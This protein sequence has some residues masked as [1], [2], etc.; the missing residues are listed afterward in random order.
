MS[1]AEQRA[2]FEEWHAEHGY[3][4][5]NY[6]GKPSHNDEWF[7]F[8]EFVDASWNAWCAALSA[9]S[10]VQEQKPFAWIR[11]RSD[12]GIEGP[13]L[14]SSRDMCDVRRKSGAWTP[15]FEYQPSSATQVAGNIMVSLADLNA[16]NAA[17]NHMGD[18]LNSIDAVEEDDENST[19]EGFEAIQRLLTTGETVTAQVEEIRNAAY[20]AAALECEKLRSSGENTDDWTITRDLAFHYCMNAIRALKTAAPFKGEGS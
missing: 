18:S 11:K 12:G 19:A 5:H 13:I 1:N 6:Q 17:M 2:A 8:D 10:S 4:G 7:Y 9:Q 14:D 20:E 3:G 16:I 15:L